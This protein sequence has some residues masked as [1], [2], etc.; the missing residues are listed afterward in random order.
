VLE[1]ATVAAY[2]NLTN[3]LNS[4]LGIHA[5]VEALQANR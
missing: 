4:A 1:A 5:N 3:R 2:F